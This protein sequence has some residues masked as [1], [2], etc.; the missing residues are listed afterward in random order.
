MAIVKIDE[1][2]LYGMKFDWAK[3]M[4]SAD[5]N[6]SFLSDQ[7]NWKNLMNILEF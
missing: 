3:K 4:F 2:A 7:S 6:A 5:A 1:M